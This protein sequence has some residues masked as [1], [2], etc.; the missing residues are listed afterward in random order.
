MLCSSIWSDAGLTLG[1]VSESA[2]INLSNA[3]IIRMQYNNI[4][5]NLN[6]SN[7]L[8]FIKLEQIQ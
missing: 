1:T 4:I 8:A 2:L 6:C 5:I 3:L 7:Y